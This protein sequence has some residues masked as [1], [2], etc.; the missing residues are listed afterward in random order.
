MRSLLRAVGLTMPL[1]IAPLLTAPALTLPVLALPLL[2]LAAC[3]EEGPAEKTGKA[4]DDAAQR[5]K[6]A[7]IPPGP[8]EKAGR[9]LDKAVQ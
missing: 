4:V 8:A 3:S 1:M 5:L 7:V 9:A 2:A 6:D